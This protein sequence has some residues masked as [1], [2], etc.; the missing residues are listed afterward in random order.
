MGKLQDVLTGYHLAGKMTFQ[1]LVAVLKFDKKE[2]VQMQEYLE[3]VRL[4]GTE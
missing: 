4:S 3:Q 2:I 1:Y